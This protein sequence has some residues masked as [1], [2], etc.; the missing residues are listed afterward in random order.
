VKL[1]HLHSYR[2]NKIEV[3]LQSIERHHAIASMQMAAPIARA[4]DRNEYLR[5]PFFLRESASGV[6][7]D[8]FAR[9]TV[10]DL[11]A[12]MDMANVTTIR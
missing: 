7:I 3:V 8:E 11:H 6:F 9:A 1:N 4:D 10:P 2:I 5:D 12:A